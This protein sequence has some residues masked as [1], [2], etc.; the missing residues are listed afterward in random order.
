MQKFKTVDEIISQLKPEE[1][2]YCIRRKSIQVASRI[3]QNK[4]PGKILYAMKANP[5]PIILD[6][7]IKSGI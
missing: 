1:P 3:F 6:T 5:H 4:F 7:I 2:I